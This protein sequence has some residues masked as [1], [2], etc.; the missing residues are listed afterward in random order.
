MNEKKGK[1]FVFGHEEIGHGDETL[2][3]EIMVQLLE[4]LEARDEK[5]VAMIFWNT[6]VNLLA[7]KSPLVSRIKTLEQKGVSILAGK[8]CVQELGLGDRLAV[9]K[10][11]GMGE[12][13]DFMFSHEVINL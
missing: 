11:A 5:P 2:G 13:L 9:G 6:A 1:V 7:D 8:L 4:G 10:S 3:F 12:I